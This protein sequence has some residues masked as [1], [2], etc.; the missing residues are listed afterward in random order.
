MLEE[1]PKVETRDGMV[2][3]KIVLK[4]ELKPGQGFQRFP[5]KRGF[6]KRLL[7]SE[8]LSE[9]S[10]SFLSAVFKGSMCCTLLL[11]LLFFLH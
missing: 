10:C 11:L 5:V 4:T 6:T 2:V 9:Q 8:K 7:E 1:A 3:L